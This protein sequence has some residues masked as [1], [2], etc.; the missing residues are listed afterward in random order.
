MQRHTKFT[1]FTD[2]KSL[3]HFD[4]LTRPRQSPNTNYFNF[5]ANIERADGILI[6]TPEYVFSI[7]SGL[8]TP[9]SGVPVTTIF[10]DKPTGLITASSPADQ[11][12]GTEALQLI[13][14]TVMTK[15]TDQ[16]ILLYKA[17]GRKSMTRTADRQTNKRP[18]GQLY[19][20]I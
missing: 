1:I 15:F 10:S 7:P 16:T 20:R 19:W 13:M 8:K 12:G 2:L 14:K 18:V 9:S 11:K 6:C 5:R 17:L 3:P 4:A